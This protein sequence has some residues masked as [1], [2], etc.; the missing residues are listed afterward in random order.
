MNHHR[1]LAIT[2]VWLG[3]AWLCASP[4]VQ[5]ERHVIRLDGAWQIAEGSMEQQ[6]VKF[7]RTVPVPGLADM[8]SPPFVAVGEPESD[9]HRRAFWYRRTFT[10]DGPAPTIAR[11]KIHK[12]AYGT[13]VWLNGQMVGEHLPCF[14]PAEFNVAKAL[15][16]A[17]GQNEL[18]VR[19]GAVRQS[20]P[21]SIPDGFDFEKA[22]YIPGIYDSVELILSDT[23]HVLRVQ[24][25][26][27]IERGQVRVLA[28]LC[29]QGKEAQVTL[30]SRVWEAKTGKVVGEASAESLRI[31]AGAERQVEAVVPIAGCRLWSPEAP[32]LYELEATTGADMLKVRFGMRSF[33]FD[34]QTKQAILNGK[35]YW[36]RGTNVCIFRF[37]EDPERGDR[38][39][40]N[41]WVRRLHDVFKS[42]HWNSARYCIGFPPEA[43]YDVADEVGILIQDEFPVWYGVPSWSGNAGWPKELRTEE[44][45]REYAEWMQ[46]RWNHP[47]VVLWDAQNETTSDETAKAIRAVRGLDRSDRP[48]DNGYGKAGRPSDTFEAHVYPTFTRAKPG[49]PESS[50]DRLPATFRYADFAKAP[51][52]PGCP[53]WPYQGSARWNDGNNPIII[54]EY[55][56]LWLNRDGSPTTLSKANYDAWL[57]PNATAD[58]RHDLY[59]RY[60][61]I[62]TEYWRSQRTVAGVLHFCGLGYARATGQTS[63]NFIDIEK[64]TLEPHFVKY[65][66]DAFAPVGLMIEHW[67]EE[68]PAGQKGDLS[69]AVLNDLYTP[70]AGE[71]HLLIARDGATVLKQHKPCHV[72]PLGRAEFHFGGALPVAPGDYTM[73]AELIGPDGESARSYRHVRVV[74][75][76]GH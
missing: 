69:V 71:V 1:C 27:E 7:D 6:P 59:A 58:Q 45:S 33:R 37:F 57:G 46:E 29:N 44:L 14:T 8:A 68:I 20:V 41:E 36:L 74:Q 13:R 32:F 55:G 61:A 16:G 3:V 28:T 19:V 24:A 2:V 30:K 67:A 4:T 66:R 43:W 39:W 18:I 9:R 60:L 21:R 42:M 52:A 40:R 50:S 73:V 51:K 17:G 31:E 76:K 25:V 56:W 35:P 65:V 49:L 23:P 48:W 11:L 47:C 15:R 63:D 38:P 26:P 10:L 54:N 22:R 34:P 70:W 64:L 72:D 75:Q 5:A 62:E 12:A 53:K